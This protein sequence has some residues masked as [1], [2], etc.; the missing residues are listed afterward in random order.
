M[1][2]RL[3]GHHLLCL[4]GYRGKGYSDGFCA[5]MTT[6]YETL[7]TQPET[8]LELIEGPDDICAAFPDD[9][10]PHCENDSVYRKDEDIL[11]LAGLR[12]GA[13]IRWSDVC[14]QVAMRVKPD[15]IGRLCRSCRWEPLGLCREG[16][17]HLAG[18]GLLR[19]LPGNAA[20]EPPT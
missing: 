9:Q 17:G 5:N 14:T 4:L 18:G 6:I 8:E 7:R 2:I 10:V 15:D 1:T 16:V 13:R 19:E 12:I 3:R 20:K 11:A